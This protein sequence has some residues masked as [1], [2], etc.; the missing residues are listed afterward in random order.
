MSDKDIFSLK[1]I[2]EEVEKLIKYTLQMKGITK[3]G[4]GDLPKIQ[5]LSLWSNNILKKK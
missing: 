1:E 4:G 5:K 3:Y 2:A